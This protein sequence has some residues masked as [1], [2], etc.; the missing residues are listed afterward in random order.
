MENSTGSEKPVSV[1]KAAESLG[2]STPAVQQAISS[3]RLVKCVVYVKAASSDRTMPK[4]IMSRIRD[5]WKRNTD[6]ARMAPSVAK[7]ET[8]S[9]PLSGEAPG[10]T[11]RPELSARAGKAV[12]H[13]LDW[14]IQ[15]A[16]EAMLREQGIRKSVEADKPESPLNAAKEK[17]AFYQAALSQLEY[18]E[19]AGKLIE[20]EK[21]KSDAFS[22]ARL[23]RDS[24][25]NVPERIASLLA[26]ESDPH[27]CFMMLKEELN[28]AL[29]SLVTDMVGTH[30]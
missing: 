5:E 21:V 2:V 17:Q 4:I 13:T 29:R 6:H 25:M 11:P 20:V 26:A 7:D 9:L 15:T 22:T 3:G 10:R 16:A 14:Q 8:P 24:V 18:E 23:V 30:A 27:K 12:E 28:V 19:K 1:K